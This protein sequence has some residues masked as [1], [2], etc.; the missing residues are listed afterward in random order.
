MLRKKDNKSETLHAK[1]CN[2]LDHVFLKEMTNIL[3]IDVKFEELF[4]PLVGD[5]ILYHDFEFMRFF[6]I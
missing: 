5:A 2:K 3:E 6:L 4:I 1:I